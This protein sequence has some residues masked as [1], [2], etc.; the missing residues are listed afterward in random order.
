MSIDQNIKEI[1]LEERTTSGK[2]NVN[3]DGIVPRHLKNLDVQQSRTKEKAEVF[4][5]VEV[6]KR[7]NDMFDEEYKGSDEEYIKRKVLEVTCGEAPYLTTLYDVSSGE[8]IPINRRVGLLD[9]K[10]QRIKTNDE[11][12]WYRLAELALKSTYGYE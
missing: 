4:T 9:R 8:E 6:V 11:K 5:P 2:L 7:M 12:E 3:V 10:L 1:L